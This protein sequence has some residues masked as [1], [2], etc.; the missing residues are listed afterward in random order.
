MFLYSLSVSLFW[1]SGFT[2]KSWFLEKSYFNVLS[3]F[4]TVLLIIIALHVNKCSSCFTLCV[5]CKCIHEYSV[6][7]TVTGMTVSLVLY[8]VQPLITPAVTLL[9]SF[10]LILISARAS[11]PIH[12][13]S[14]YV[15]LKAK[16][17]ITCMFSPNWHIWCFLRLF[18]FTVFI[19]VHP[20]AKKKRFQCET[21]LMSFQL[22]CYFFDLHE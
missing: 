12:R 21:F 4:T 18:L 16:L 14:R 10:L 9:S 6:V 13:I 17:I 7:S 8:S 1:S 15:T 5:H 2:F 19:F 22:V 11:P 20:A 3:F